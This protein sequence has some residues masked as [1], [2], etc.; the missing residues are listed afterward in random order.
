MISHHPPPPTYLS[1]FH[2]HAYNNNNDNNHSRKLHNP[3]YLFYLWSQ[4]HPETEFDCVWFVEYGSCWSV[5]Y[6]RLGENT[7]VFELYAKEKKEME[8]EEEEE[9]R[10]GGGCPTWFGLLFFIFHGILSNQL[11]WLGLESGCSVVWDD[12]GKYVR[13]GKW[14]WCRWIELYFFFLFFWEVRV[15]YLLVRF[16]EDLLYPKEGESMAR[17]QGEGG[18]RLGGVYIYH[19]RLLTRRL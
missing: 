11:Y 8:M 18:G 9:G 15:T 4:S 7:L 16:A 2:F 19:Y 5:G 3:I 17:E 12:F 10:E 6:L 13:W 1:H 14:G